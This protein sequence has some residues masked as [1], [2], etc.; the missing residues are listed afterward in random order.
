[1]ST[2]RCPHCN[3]EIELLGPKELKDEYGLGPN[4]VAYRREHKG[5]PEPVLSFNNRHIY[6]RDEVEAW[7]QEDAKGKIEKF[8]ANMQETLA[9]LPEAEREAAVKMLTD[10]KVLSPEYGRKRAH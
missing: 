6:L 3:T 7:I 5:F 2:L 10:G 8:V 9:A 1:M 4:P